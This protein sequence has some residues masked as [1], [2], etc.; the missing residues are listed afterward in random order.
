MFNLRPYPVYLGIKG[1]FALFFMLWATVASVY[2]IE[3]VGLDPLRLVLLGTA[4]EVAVLVFEVPTGVL[5]DSHGRRRSVITGFLLMGSGFALEGAIPVFWAVL[6]AQAVWGVGYTFISGALEAWIADEAPERDLGR[7]Y[8][9]GEQADYAGSLLGVILS[10]ALATY[11]LN[12]P[13]LMGGFLTI[14]LGVALFFAMPERN[15]SPSPREGRSSL[16]QVRA[17]AGGGVRLVRARPVLLI[18]LAVAVF[19]GMSEE[20]FDRLYAKHFLDG[21]GLP[22]F[23]ALD[24]VVWFGVI[25]AGSLVLSYLAAEVLGRRM[26]VGDPAVVA[27]LLLVLNACTIVGMLSF[28]LAGSFALALAAF[29][30]ASLSRTLAEPLYLTWLN[31]GLEPGVRATVISM[32]SQAG[33]FGEA[34]AGPVVGAIGN[35]AGVRAALTVA[36]IILSPALL[37]YARAIRHRGRPDLEEVPDKRA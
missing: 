6:I 30:F 33:A 37:L 34:S 16:Q 25:S 10:V 20:G 31:E 7:V 29:W 26:N 11:T 36:S 23:G 18:L 17:T 8:L 3:E 9:R 35:L 24:P 21:L 5:A 4:L 28:A 27:R 15:F 13:L 14:G 32:G 1:A 19:T 2:R 22:A 12:L